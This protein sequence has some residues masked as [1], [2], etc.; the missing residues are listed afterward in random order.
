[1]Q[2]IPAI[3]AVAKARGI[4]TLIDNT[5]AT[6]L[7][8][9][10]H[11]FGMTSRSGRHQISGRPCGPQPRHRLGKGDAWK[12]LSPPMATWASASART[13][14]RSACAALRTLAVASPA[15]ASGLEVARGWKLRLMS[16]GSCIRRWRATRPCGLE[17]G[18]HRRMRPVQPDPE[19]GARGGG[20]HFFDSLKLFGMGIPGAASNASPSPSTAPATA[21][22][23]GRRKAGRAAPHR[24][25]RAGGHHR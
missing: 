12:G 1:M 21:R 8:F 23:S 19:A 24:P 20:G 25:R 3:V 4:T 6:P 2:D 18:F 14:R 15:Q 13:M 9:K 5:W 22:P 7:F 11:A 10:P 16:R 17:A